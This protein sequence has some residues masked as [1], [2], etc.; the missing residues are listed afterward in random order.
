MV[1]FKAIADDLGIE[2]CKLEKGSPYLGYID[3]DDDCMIVALSIMTEKDYGFTLEFINKITRETDR[4]RTD[5]RVCIDFINN[6]NEDPLNKY[7]FIPLKENGICYNMILRNKD[8][9]L[10]IINNTH[11]FCYVNGKI[12]ETDGNYLATDVSGCKISNFVFERIE[13]PKTYKFKK[14]GY[15]PK[16]VD[17]NS[18][19]DSEFLLKN[20][21]NKVKVLKE[22]TEEETL[23]N[24]PILALSRLTNIP[25]KEAAMTLVLFDDNHTGISSNL[26]YSYLSETYETKNKSYSGKERNYNLYSFLT[27]DETEKS[28]FMVIYV[29]MIFG[30]WKDNLFPVAVKDGVIQSTADCIE[31]LLSSPVTNVQYICTK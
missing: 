1:H 31:I 22:P 24:L 20:L 3:L 9:D 27:S 2:V 5:P 6:Y 19:E 18:L 30:S 16:A 7:V 14:I 15:K 26:L 25:Y 10:M 17:F 21:D 12:V 29:K 4:F 11:V 28:K 8:K 13:R 23:F